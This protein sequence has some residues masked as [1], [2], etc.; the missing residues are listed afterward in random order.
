MQDGEAVTCRIHKSSADEKLGISFWPRTD[1]IVSIRRIAEDGLAASAG[2][3]VYDHVV[4]VCGERV[5]SA[6]DAAKLLRDASGTVS[7]DVVR[8][9]ADDFDYISLAVG[10]DSREEVE[11]S[12]SEEE[13]HLEE[14]EG[15]DGC[16]DEA[17]TDEWE[18]WLGWMIERIMSRESEL[19]HLQDATADVIA[20]TMRAAE[21]PPAPPSEAEMED[22]TAM[23]AYM[24]RM[25]AFSHRQQVQLEDVDE[26]AE[27][28]REA[29]AALALLVARRQELEAFRERVDE[30]TAD[31]ADRIEGI[32]REL[33]C[34]DE[35]EEEGSEASGTE[36]SVGYDTDEDGAV[37]DDEDDDERE[38]E[39]FVD[40]PDGVHACDVDDIEVEKILMGVKHKPAAQKPTQEAAPS[41]AS[42]T[43][44]AAPAVAPKPEAARPTHLKTLSAVD[45]NRSFE[46]GSARSMLSKR[47]ISKPDVFGEL[48]S[49]YQQRLKRARSKGVVALPAHLD[50]WLRETGVKVHPL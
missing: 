17:T 30:L 39:E 5:T 24:E 37:V 43:P 16:Y 26:E 45:V 42:P 29:T 32:W 44:E 36:E 31:D 28:N 27:E 6:L 8:G 22:P 1:G 47:V 7:L 13:G 11:R 12:C 41:A 35:G 46:A 50:P 2:L 49:P 33:A 3:E 20:Q 4:F 23:A 34:D 19:Q 18:E 38:G 14:E 21:A 10:T 15:E 9:A 40:G 48:E 25:A